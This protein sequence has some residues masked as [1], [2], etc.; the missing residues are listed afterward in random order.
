MKRLIYIFLLLFTVQIVLGQHAQNPRKLRLNDNT[1][2]MGVSAYT[3]TLPLWTPSTLYDN[4]VAWDTTDMI[5]YYWDFINS[6]WDTLDVSATNYNFSNAL[7]KV[8]SEVK[9][10]GTLIENTDVDFNLS[11]TL[12]F[13]APTQS[14]SFEEILRFYT[15]YSNDDAT[16]DFISFVSPH[17]SLNIRS[18]DK[19]IYFNYFGGVD[20]GLYFDSNNKNI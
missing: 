9:F 5:Y 4:Y 15:P 7:T 19:K 10:G 3:D 13:N 1:T 11:K 12:N 20:G 16:T 2:S 17:D 8:G 14:G 18:Y 6:E